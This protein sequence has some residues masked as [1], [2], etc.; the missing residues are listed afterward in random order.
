MTCFTPL[1]GHWGPGGQVRFDGSGWLDRPV[2]VPCGQCRGCRLA[3]ARAWAVRCYH[4][5]QFHAVNSFITLTY[6]RESVNS[7]GGLDHRHWQLFAK[8]VRKALGPFRFYMCGEYGE[9]NRRPHYHAVVFGLDFSPYRQELRRTQ[10]TRLFESEQLT[11]L[12]GLGHASVG[13]FSLESAA[14]VARYC[15]KKLGG[16]EGAAEY[17]RYDSTT[18]EVWSVRPPY[19]AMSRRPGLG[20]KWFDQFK[21]DVFPRDE[22][23]VAGKRMRPP[24]FYDVRFQSLCEEE[25]ARIKAARVKRAEA[26]SWDTSPQR[27]RVREEI[28]RLDDQKRY[29]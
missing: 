1:D 19:S 18:G 3:R 12:W 5:A 20:S 10:K 13:A 15:M 6:N 24:R 8:R 25:F 21:S 28:A 11:N 9:E 2:R 23:V 29:L 16:T 27:L 26:R 22:V 4:E 17:E 14:Y 7:D